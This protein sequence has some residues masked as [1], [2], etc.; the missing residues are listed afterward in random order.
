MLE[1]SIVILVAL[2]ELMDLSQRLHRSRPGKVA[3]TFLDDEGGPE[4]T[5]SLGK[6]DPSFLAI[7]VVAPR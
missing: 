7:V 2:P 3:L 1:P 4:P 6:A 5:R